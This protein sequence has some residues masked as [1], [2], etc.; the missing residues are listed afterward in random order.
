M[1]KHS[2]GKA[3]ATDEQKTGASL[4]VGRAFH[5]FH[6]DKTVK[7]QGQVIGDLGNGFYLVQLFRM[8][9]R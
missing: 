6:S 8:V 2:T 5:T 1:T 7:W 9:P 4:L 3:T